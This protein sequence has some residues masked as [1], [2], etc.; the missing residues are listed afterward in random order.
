LCIRRF[1]RAQGV[2]R[3]GLLDSEFC[4][5]VVACITRDARCPYGSGIAGIRP[6][7]RCSFEAR[8][9][10]GTVVELDGSP[11]LWITGHD[12]NPRWAGDT[13]AL[14]AVA[15]RWDSR[16]TMDLDFLLR[17]TKGDPYL[18]AG[19]VK[20]GDP[21]Y[22]AKWE[23]NEPQP[24]LLHILSITDVEL[25]G[26]DANNYTRF[27]LER[28]EWQRRFPFNTDSLRRAELP[29]VAPPGATAPRAP[30]A[31]PQPAP[32]SPPAPPTAQPTPRP[33]PPTPAPLSVVPP[34]RPFP[35]FPCLAANPSC[36]RDPW[37]A[38]WNQLTRT[39]PVTY[40]FAPGLVTDVSAQLN[41]PPS[42]STKFPI[43]GS[44]TG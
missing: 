12:G 6:R 5:E 20:I 35:E 28:D 42:C 39:D 11:H 31:Q 32:T 17:V 34:P 27:V 44:A 8:Y 2:N 25:F 26:I 9:P 36:G 18:S 10:A 21:I 1:H 41:S 40:A 7:P 24:T 4:F 43:T 30:P 38:E 13:R 15:V 3:S 22:L 14:E 37:W 33:I 29:Q 23:T 19:L 16:C